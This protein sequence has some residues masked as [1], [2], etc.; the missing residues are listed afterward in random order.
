MYSM[1]NVRTG[2]VTLLSATQGGIQGN[3]SASVTDASS[4]LT[5]V[6]IMSGA[7]NFGNGTGGSDTNGLADIFLKKHADRGT[8]QRLDRRWRQRRAGQWHVRGRPCFRRRPLCGVHV[9]RIEPRHRR[10]QHLQ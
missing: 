7:T 6:A 10:H 9:Q 4:D 8:P 2:E 5:W 3:S 1:K